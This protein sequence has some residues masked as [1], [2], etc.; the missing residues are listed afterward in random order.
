LVCFRLSFGDRGGGSAGGAG[1]TLCI[2]SF[3]LPL[4]DF[5]APHPAGTVVFCLGSHVLAEGGGVFFLLRSGRPILTFPLRGGEWV[6]PCFSFLPRSP[7]PPH[8][9]SYRFLSVPQYPLACR[10]LAS[11][12]RPSTIFLSWVGW[13]VYL[14]TL[15]GCG[16]RLRLS[17]SVPFRH[18]PLSSSTPLNC[19]GVGS[20]FLS[21]G[22]A[23][24]LY[25]PP[26]S[27][28]PTMSALFFC[29]PY[30]SDR[31]LLA[32]TPLPLMVGVG[33]ERVLGM[34]IFL[35]GY[36]YTSP[37]W[38]PWGE[39]YTDLSFFLFPARVVGGGALVFLGGGLG[40]GCFFLITWVAAASLGGG[41]GGGGG[42]G[43]FF[44]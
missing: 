32:R 18:G 28:T 1:T 14:L 13:I 43:V 42:G 10:L 11:P 6:C 19:G 40:R 15:S 3:F 4:L 12:Q 23:L 38:R 35:F 36:S 31:L 33:A 5:G 2:S 17:S 41:F 7:P 34:G 39:R 26:S 16:F 44:F 20:F 27:S 9:C 8:P 29:A 21:G 22:A 37:S 25:A 30:A 24:I